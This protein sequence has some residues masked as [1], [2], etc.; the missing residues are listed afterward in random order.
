[1]PLYEI[2]SGQRLKAIQHKSFQQV[3]FKEQQNLQALLRYDISAVSSDLMMISEEFSEW[4]D[5]NRRVDLLALER[6]DMNLAIIE[7]KRVDDGGHMELQAIRYAA[8]VAPM[9]FEQVVDA[10][11]RFLRKQGRDPKPPAMKFL[12]F[13][14]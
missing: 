2:E 1:M 11:Q 13:W 12:N 3:A 9:D 14:R 4:D 5:G 10:H 6:R 7:L 8:M